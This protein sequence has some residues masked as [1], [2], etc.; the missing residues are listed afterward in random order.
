MATTSKKKKNNNDPNQAFKNSKKSKTSTYDSVTNRQ[1]NKA[2]KDAKKSTTSSQ[3]SKEKAVQSSQKA[4]QSYNESKNQT[5]KNNKQSGL[6]S[7][8][9]GYQN[10]K[11]AQAKQ[12]KAQDKYKGKT[13]KQVIGEASKNA[14][15][16]YREDEDK[17]PKPKK[18]EPYKDTRT[19]GS[20]GKTKEEK[21]QSLQE[22]F[23]KA[24]ETNALGGKVETRKAGSEKTLSANLD[25]LTTRTAVLGEV[26][27]ASDP[28]AWKNATKEEKKQVI[29]DAYKEITGKSIKKNEKEIDEAYKELDSRVSSK[30]LTSEAYL[31]L[32]NGLRIGGVGDLTARAMG[33]TQFKRDKNGNIMYDE[34]GNPIVEKYSD[35]AQ[36]F[37]SRTAYDYARNGWSRGAMGFVEGMS[38]GDN[39]SPFR[40]LYTDQEAQAIREGEQSGSY[41]AGNILGQF[42]SYAL[43]GGAS[44]ALGKTMASKVGKSYL[45]TVGAEALGQTIVNTPQNLLD[46]WKRSNDVQDGTDP[47]QMFDNMALNTLLDFGLGSAFGGV[48]AILK[49][50]QIQKAARIQNKL[51]NSLDLTPEEEKFLEKLGQKVSD[52]GYN[53]YDSMLKTVN[54]E[55]GSIS[56]KNQHKLN[57]AIKKGAEQTEEFEAKIKKASAIARQQN[58]EHA[59]KQF[60]SEAGEVSKTPPPKKSG[61][62]P[63]VEHQAKREEFEQAN[64]HQEEAITSKIEKN[65]ARRDEIQRELNKKKGNLKRTKNEKVREARN[66]EIEELESELKNIDDSAPRSTSYVKRDGMIVDKETGEVAHEMTSVEKEINQ[67]KE[68]K[69]KYEQRIRELESKETL[70]TLEARDLRLA[71]E[72][73]KDID[74]KLSKAYTSSP[75]KPSE[76]ATKAIHVPKKADST[77]VQH[78]GMK[79]D[80]ETGEVLSKESAPEPKAETPKAE[81]PSAEAPKAEEPKP[82]ASKGKGSNSEEMSELEKGRKKRNSLNKGASNIRENF[83]A[84]H[85]DEE[86]P[87][88]LAEKADALEAKAREVDENNLELWKKEQD[89]KKAK[90]LQAKKDKESET[91]EGYLKSENFGH[92]GHPKKAEV[93][94]ASKNAVDF[95][96]QSNNILSEFWRHMGDELSP[97]ERLANLVSKTDYATA[98]KIRASLNRMRTINTLHSLAVTGKASKGMGQVNFAGKKIGDSL[99]EIRREAGLMKDEPSKLL[100]GRTKEMDYDEYCRLKFHLEMLE[101][102]DS[103]E[104]LLSAIHSDVDTEIERVKMFINDFEKAYGD[105]I[106]TY[107]KKMV[108]FADNNL[109]YAVDGGL[110][111]TVTAK[112]FR[113]YKNYI[114]TYRVNDLKTYGDFEDVSAGF[115]TRGAFRK[116]K[117]ANDTPF[118]PLYQS[119]MAH[120]AQI[121]KRTEQNNLLTMLHK[122]V[123]FENIEFKTLEKN[124]KDS[125]IIEAIDHAVFISKNNKT[126][127]Q[128]ATFFETQPKKK[129]DKDGKVV[130]DENGEPA[131]E[132]EKRVDENGKPV[133]DENGDE[134]W[135]V[136]TESV[137][138]RM[139]L[140][141][142]AV[143]AL[144]SWSGEEQLAFLKWRIGVGKV[145]FEVKDAL[146]V[147]GTANRLFKDLITGWNPIFGAKNLVRDTQTAMVN[148]QYGIPN[149]IRNYGRAVEQMLNNGELFKAYKES[150]GVYSTMVKDAQEGF[151]RFSKLNPFK[152]FEEFNN[153]L[154]TIPRFAEFCASAEASA[155]KK[156]VALDGL[157]S[158]DKIAK[159]MGSMGREER[160]LAISESKEVTVNFA[161]SGQLG[162]LLNT[163][164]VPYFNPALQGMYKIFKTGRN[165]FQKDFLTGTKYIATLMGMGA[166]G[167][168]IF[169]AMMRN[170]ED[171][172]QL[173]SY[174]KNTYYCI[175]LGN[176]HFLKI[177]KAR[178]LSAVGVPFEWI[179]RTAV[180]GTEDGSFKD[181]LWTSWEQVGASVNPLEDN[182][183]SPFTRLWTGKNWYGEDLENEDDKL[184]LAMGKSE[185]VYDQNTS[186]VAIA[187]ANLPWAKKLNLSPKRIDSVLDGYGGMIYDLGISQTSM[188]AKEYGL[189]SPL[190]NNFVIDSTVKNRNASDFYVKCDEY[191][192]T[193][194]YYEEK[195]NTDNDEYKKAKEWV[196]Q[197]SYNS[198][199]VTKAINEIQLDKKMN[200]KLKYKQL[201][202]LKAI[203]NQIQKAGING[204]PID[205]DPVAEVAGVIGIDKTFSSKTIM[206][207]K[208]GGLLE[209]TANT[210]RAIGNGTDTPYSKNNVYFDKWKEIKKNGNWDKASAEERRKMQEDFFAIYNAS[211]RAEMDGGGST[212]YPD[213]TTVALSATLTEKNAKGQKISKKVREAFLNSA[214]ESTMKDVNAYVEAGGDLKSWGKDLKVLNDTAKELGVEYS[215]ELTDGTRTLAIAG[216]RMK[217]QEFVITGT[218]KR[219]NAGRWAT[220]DGI[221]PQAFESW[222]KDHGFNKYTDKEEIVD[223][224]NKTSWIKGDNMKAEV[225]ALAYGYYQKNT[226]WGRLP[227]YKMDGDMELGGSGGGH[228]RRRHRR[229]HGGGGGSSKIKDYNKWLK[230]HTSS[231]SGGSSSKASKSSL[232]EAFRRQQL[233]KLQATSGTLKT[234]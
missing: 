39:T 132:V 71:K 136:A 1:N 7:A 115:T 19:W 74:S 106:K 100:S 203:Q 141:T 162:K 69:T 218:D 204:T 182:L 225:F 146:R 169:E 82:K 213:F 116:R 67:L 5:T 232:T 36:D 194:K 128:E 158:A 201:H 210:A 196:E 135:D 72:E 131:W 102:G 6:S 33:E 208:L 134:I 125:D 197:Y 73:I 109:Q 57:Q 18:I 180:I 220:D 17:K 91:T 119:M 113:R 186:Q 147:M 92:S 96:D 222:M 55:D 153:A 65:K 160:V 107:Q 231:G 59:T 8:S 184:L 111:D 99:D 118:V 43:T 81:E 61:D 41:L 181:A 64:K 108:K 101:N 22:A 175:P 164:F 78:N 138:V 157:S 16:K 95:A 211:A 40:N 117:G 185:L 163:S 176:D 205:I 63:N 47:N 11:D 130:L 187:L 143:K 190:I 30:D 219:M 191:Y 84:K 29:R 53:D 200:A 148:T 76:E 13:T 207:K 127:K 224:I 209:E 2:S 206:N 183:F 177:P 121:M 226:P 168:V 178:D 77:P 10:Y 42:G 139:E 9:K 150:G 97:Y 20:G 149:Y 75:V 230:E 221:T 44:G 167:G 38:F 166:G 112:H 89:E 154:E 31:R 105:S 80:S 86:L 122:S 32:Q 103:N 140:P 34:N 88:D 214:Y 27:K 26:K 217:S 110:V 21:K 12:Q 159:I 28:E 52:T 145:S 66:K 227:E 156:G 229:G 98:T 24:K 58:I 93:K 87:Q 155:I 137:Q 228:G 46:A 198:S 215:N 234:K 161:R 3:K 192:T 202:E 199:T 45:K 48:G 70:N 216:A 79:V 151:N 193:M 35:Y 94:Q 126:G 170:N 104:R 23:N 83:N 62:E 15:T 90:E 120:N 171:Y 212:L 133:L 165:S 49:K 174:T 129:L 223:A 123:N 51:Q 124:I 37:A 85:P 173:T 60:E 188:S 152:A 54:G 179:Y 68:N 4:Y 189:L 142:D 144:K 25:K 14:F 56:L 50:G 114:P 172:Q 195:G 233:K